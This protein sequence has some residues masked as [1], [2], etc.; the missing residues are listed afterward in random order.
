META[1]VI[2]TSM[3]ESDSHGPLKSRSTEGQALSRGRST[4]QLLANRAGSSV[5]MPE[6]TWT[7]NK[8]DKAKVFGATHSFC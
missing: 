5:G 2:L 6:T 8:H 3:S 4:A 1:A 7:G